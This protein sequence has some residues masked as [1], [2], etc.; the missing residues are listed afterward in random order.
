MSGPAA[1]SSGRPVAVVTGSGRRRIG[2]HVAS[3]LA[4]EGYA[5]VLHYRTAAQ[6]AAQNAQELS[7]HY[8]VP[9]RTAAADL[10]VERQVQELVQTT[11]EQFGRVDVVVHCAAIWKRKSLEET[12][13]ADVREHFEVNLLS[14]FL[15]CQTFGLQMVR[16]EQGGCLVTIGDW[17]DIRPYPDYAA[18]F[19][20]K[21]AIPGLTRTMAV[22]LGQ[23]HPRVRVNAVLPGPVMLPEDLPA[24]ERQAVIAATLLKREGKPEHVAQAVWHFVQNDYL[25]GVCLPVDGGRSIYAGGW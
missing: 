15:I 11:L 20:S 18:Y 16:Q 13:A 22:E 6:E 25:T 4:Q 7:Q 9:V 23:R 2:Y 14:T 12:T 24:E 5:L 3:R 8:G 17:A 19:A 1:G 21:A 10:T